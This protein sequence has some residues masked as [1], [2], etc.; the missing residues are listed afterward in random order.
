MHLVL[1]FL[2]ILT[3]SM[4]FVCEC[5]N[6]CTNEEYWLSPCIEMYWTDLTRPWP[7]SYYRWS[8][9]WKLRGWQTWKLHH[10]C[11]ETRKQ[12]NGNL[13]PDETQTH[14]MF[15]ASLALCWTC[16]WKH[17]VWPIFSSWDLLM[18]RVFYNHAQRWHRIEN[19]VF[20]EKRT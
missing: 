9:E 19:F 20:I 14:N 17:S 10:S 15:I 13:I 18:F 12:P 11:Q 4:Q 7:T 6:V 5:A 3:L 2:A 16:S 8:S 1:A